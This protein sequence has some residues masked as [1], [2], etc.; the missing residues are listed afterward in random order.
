MCPAGAGLTRRLRRASSFGLRS[1][2]IVPCLCC[3]CSCLQKNKTAD[4]TKTD[5]IG[6]VSVDIF[7]KDISVRIRQYHLET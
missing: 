3:V 2:P 6:F 7:C 1:K 4:K 5:T